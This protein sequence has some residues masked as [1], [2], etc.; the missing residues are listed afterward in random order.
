[1]RRAQLFLL[2]NMVT[3][4]NQCWGNDGGKWGNGWHEQGSG[5]SFSPQGSS[6]HS[7][8]SSW[9]T[10]HGGWQHSSNSWKHGQ[11]ERKAWEEWTDRSKEWWDKTS[12]D[13]HGHCSTL[14]LK[15]PLPLDDRKELLHQ[16]MAAGC[17]QVTF[18]RMAVFNWG[19]RVVHA[20]FMILARAEPGSPVRMLRDENGLY[21]TAC[22]KSFVGVISGVIRNPRRAP[23][24]SRQAAT[25]LL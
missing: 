19:A 25:E 17:P 13:K 24:S 9:S 15:H 5:W 1:M 23:G 20:A 8:P 21:T 3:V 10:D 22:L 14:G 6:W 18:P 12:K 11:V 7:N 2:V 16:L 4:D